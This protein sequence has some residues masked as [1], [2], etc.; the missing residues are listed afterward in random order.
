MNRVFTRYVLG[1]LHAVVKIVSDMRVG[2]VF[3]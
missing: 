3:Q 2:F 1:T